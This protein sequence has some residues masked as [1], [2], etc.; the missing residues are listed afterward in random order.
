MLKYE[1]THES[2]ADTKKEG[3]ASKEV[4]LVLA[5][6]ERHNSTDNLPYPQ[7]ARSL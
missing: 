2:I 7:R 3:D 5:C 4:D 1:R 6:T